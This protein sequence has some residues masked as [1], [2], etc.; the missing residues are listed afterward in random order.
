MNDIITIEFDLFL[1]RLI[2]QMKQMLGTSYE[3]QHKQINKNNGI[4]AECLTIKEVREDIA[5]SFR[6]DDYYEMYKKG[7]PMNRIGEKVLECYLVNQSRYAGDDCMNDYRRIRDKIFFRLV[8][9]EMNKNLLHQVPHK[10]VLDLCI[11]FHCLV[12]E[13]KSG[14]GAVQITNAHC[15][16]WEVSLENL[17]QDAMYNTVRMFPPILRTMDEVMRD[18]LRSEIEASRQKNPEEEPLIPEEV[19]I[20]EMMK[21]MM[22]HP[23]DSRPQIY[24]LTNQKGINGAS[25]LLYPG[26]QQA[27][28]RQ[29]KEDYYILPSS[30]HEVLLV[31]VYEREE[32]LASMVEEV[33]KTQVPLEDILSD[34]VYRYSSVKEVLAAFPA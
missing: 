6:L 1:N 20:E 8:N 29:M 21:L 15:E 26:I 12:K 16:R 31:P 17:L 33:N 19:A 4:V 28:S 32:N 34:H 5:Q 18:I 3:I 14:I 9:R 25:C 24:V 11:T 7:E 10:S 27:I 23:D 30:I 22:P 2:H 13:E